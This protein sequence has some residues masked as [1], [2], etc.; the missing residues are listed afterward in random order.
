[1]V[2]HKTIKKSFFEIFNSIQSIHSISNQLTKISFLENS[3]CIF[4][5]V[6]SKYEEINNLSE[7]L[8]EL[9]VKLKDQKKQIE[10]FSNYQGKLE[11]A[12]QV[13]HDIRSPLS[14]LNMVA[15]TL[16]QIPEE[17]RLLIRN[18]IQ[19][20]NDIA[21]ALLEKSNREDSHWKKTTANASNLSL[22]FRT[23]HLPTVIDVIISEKR[24][25]F[26]D[27]INIS[28]ESDL[29]NSYGSFAN[30]NGA[31]LKRVVSNLINNSVEA[32]V[33]QTGKVLVSVKNEKDLIKIIISDNGK[34]I[35][36]HIL[37]KLGEEGVTYG[38]EGTN[39]G[40]G[41]GIYH[42]KKTIE[43]FDG[44]FKID[45]QE[46]SG[47]TISIIFPKIKTPAWFM[48]RIFIT[49]GVS[50]VS[51]DDD[52][53]IHGIWRGRLHS[54]GHDLKRFNHLSF[55]SGEEFKKWIHSK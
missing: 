45:S 33:N 34:G 35:P 26:R 16:D 44:I 14:A 21:N 28:L 38:K 52:L 36:I 48:E 23:E 39:S 31:E 19:R 1:M 15:F 12:K 4:T 5:K 50:I 53:S 24:M 8:Y 3:Q 11:L 25:Q 29:L 43:S 20:I 2:T 51:V 13:A 55:T 30:V 18:A 9:I 49:T 7:K 22:K 42:A 46:E 6:D 37:Q 54:L 32:F 47:T 10:S 41:L 17:R 27:Q 40:F